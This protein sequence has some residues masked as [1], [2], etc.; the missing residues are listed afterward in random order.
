MKIK[1]IIALFMT[2]T[3][4]GGLVACGNSGKEQGKDGDKTNTETLDWTPGADASGGDVTLRVSTWR[5]SDKAVYEEVEKRFEE[6]YDWID[7][8][9]EFNQSTDSYYS[10]LNADLM[11][12]TAP[13]VFE[14]HPSTT[15]FLSFVKAGMVAPQDG[16]DYLA[17]YSD[18]GKKVTEIDGKNMGYLMTYNYF[19]V[20][21]NKDIFAKEGISV[22]TT[23]EELVDVVN[24]LKTA[25]YGGLA[26]PGQ[27]WA[28]S[29]IGENLLLASLGTDGYAALQ[30]G[31]D[32]GAI[33]DISEVEGV[34]E[35]LKAAELYTKSNIF[36]NAYESM[37]ADVALSLLAQEK[38]AMVY[39]G[40]FLF[41]SEKETY[42]PDVNVGY[43][44]LPTYANNGVSFSEG[45]QTLLIN[46]ASK[47]LGAAKLWVEFMASQEIASY[48]LN[49][50]KMLSTIN[51]VEATFEEASIV[52]EYVTGYAI[53][54]LSLTKNSEYWT[55]GWNNL[56]TSIISDGES[57]E[58]SARVFQSKLEEYDLANLK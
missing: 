37:S 26:F 6:K 55:V 47:N 46:A 8:Q 44:P 15:H 42:I 3:M 35:A 53:K 45:G 13:D 27:T 2:V 40:T 28:T 4:L 56:L 16:F 18:A 52:N 20:L 21:Y 54:A 36:Y 29:K 24:K 17:N 22:P 19:G 5:L 33:T 14:S 48:F 58:G 39:E 25:G 9:V 43:F 30:D 51:G 57:W 31:I 11:G 7:V 12:G 49:E 23:P 38:T 32:S 34:E 10:N 1:K 50:V 41:G